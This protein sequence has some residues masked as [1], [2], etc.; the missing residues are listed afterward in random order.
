MMR[1]RAWCLAMAMGLCGAGRWAVAQEAP[2]SPKSQEP[3]GVPPVSDDKEVRL[4]ALIHDLNQIPQGQLSEKVD[5]ALG[6]LRS[7]YDLDGPAFQLL[8]KLLG[9]ADVRA[10]LNPSARAVFAGLLSQRW[11]SFTLAGNLWLGALSSENPEYRL[12]ARQRLPGFI[13]PAHIPALIHWLKKPGAGVVAYEVLKDVTAQGFAPE[14]KDWQS[15]W[16]NA[17]GRFDFAGTL[18]HGVQLDVARYRVRTF[19]QE[20]FWYLPDGVKRSDTPYDQRSSYEQVLISHWNDWVGNDVRNFTEDMQVAKPLL[21]RVIHHDDSRILPFLTDLLK[22]PGL[23][24]YAAKVLAWRGSQAALEP[25]KQGYRQA[26][27]PGKA[28][29]RGLLGD[30][31]A[32]RDLLDLME[33]HPQPL[34]YGIMDANARNYADLLPGHGILSAE[35]AFERLVNKS[36]GLLEAKRKKEKRAAVSKAKRW[37]KKRYDKLVFDQTRGVFSGPFE[38][39]SRNPTPTGPT[40]PGSQE[41]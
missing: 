31:D 40:P 38:E 27:S 18:L 37:L 16:K 19:A 1:T 22:D 8:R 24:D 26:P 30:K 36:F 10:P 35:Q 13:Q 3:P 25:L 7:M 14:P 4:L 34:S 17:G 29:A 28:L 2:P 33:K 5:P 6:I 39:P 15:W 9:T 21:E 11:D 12:R 32:L 20:A 23:G 41:G